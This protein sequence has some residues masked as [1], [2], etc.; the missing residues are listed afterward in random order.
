ML[1]Q[2]GRNAAV[3]LVCRSP[4]SRADA[5]LYTEEARTLAAAPAERALV[6]GLS[7]ATTELLLANMNEGPR[8]LEGGRSPS[9]GPARPTAPPPKG[10]VVHAPALREVELASRSV[11]LQY[12]YPGALPPD[13]SPV[14][15]AAAGRTAVPRTADEMLDAIA[16]RGDR[17]S[18]AG[19]PARAVPPSRKS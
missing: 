17:R 15:P 3:A 13:A 6:D 14:R 11:A 4:V 8:L 19:L 1:N 9:D 10:P 16:R 12:G 18:G 5:C 2:E 7:G